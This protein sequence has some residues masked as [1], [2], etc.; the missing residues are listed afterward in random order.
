MSS[1]SEF[2]DRNHEAKGYR[3]IE[4]FDIKI[5]AALNK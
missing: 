5:S 2:A 3:M 4:S 1:I